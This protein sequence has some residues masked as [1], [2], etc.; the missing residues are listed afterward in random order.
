MSTTCEHKRPRDT[1][2]MPAALQKHTGTSMALGAHRDGAAAAVRRE[3]HE[4]GRHRPRLGHGGRDGE[5]RCWTRETISDVHLRDPARSVEVT[6]ACHHLTAVAIVGDVFAQSGTEVEGRV[7]PLS[8]LYVVLFGLP[9]QSEPDDVT[10]DGSGQWRPTDD[11]CGCGRRRSAG[12]V[13]RRAA[14]LLHED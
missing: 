1:P 12:S 10:D 11:A 9:C 3:R 14:C 13:V 8:G 6:L 7:C 2:V 5:T 4:R